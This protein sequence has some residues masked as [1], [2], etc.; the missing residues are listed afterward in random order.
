MNSFKMLDR[1]YIKSLLT[2]VSKFCYKIK[3]ANIM[4]M[5]LFIMF[6]SSLL[7]LTM[8]QY[9]QHMIQISWVFQDYY[10]AYYYAYG[11]LELWL[12]QAKFHTY[13]FEDGVNNDFIFSDYLTCSGTSVTCETDITVQSRWNPIAD[14]YSNDYNTCGWLVAAASTT[15][16]AYVLDAGD[17]LIIPLF[18]DANTW[19][20]TSTPS[21]VGIEFDSGTDPLSGYDPIIY[22]TGQSG[23][24]GTETYVVKIID[25]DLEN[26]NV[27]LSPTLDDSPYDVWTS[28][29]TAYGGYSGSATNRN[30]LVI[31]NATGSTKEFCIQVNEG[32]RMI[33]KYVMI[34]SIGSY[35]NTSASLSALKINQ[36]PSFLTYGTITS[37]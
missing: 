3:Q 17:A 31:A 20:S 29:D 27:T 13:K 19:F 16:T 23:A 4:L 37:R 35:K 6:V 2:R 12:A 5:V 32:K 7:W 8:A 30:Y 22:A 11:W 26:Y 15:H 25:Y 14:S 33:S 18:Y 28:L 1:W 36:L 34:D 21:Y 24:F 10:K 9:V